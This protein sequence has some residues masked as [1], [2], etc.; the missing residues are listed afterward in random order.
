MDDGIRHRGAKGHVKYWARINSRSKEL[1]PS[2]ALRPGWDYA[3]TEVVRC[4]S[5]D[6]D[7]VWS[8]AEKCVPRYLRTTL[9]QSPAVVIGALGAHAGVTTINVGGTD[10]LLAFLPHPNARKVPKSFEKNIKPQQLR[11]LQ[12]R[13]REDGGQE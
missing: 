5:W 4:K 8:A 10:R 12:T 13:L 7:A 1:L 9:E 2:G 6:E 11:R 3:L